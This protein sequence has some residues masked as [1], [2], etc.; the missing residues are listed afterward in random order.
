M[1]GGIEKE[2]AAM[3]LANLVTMCAE[4]GD[5]IHCTE[6]GAEETFIRDLEAT[7]EAVRHE[8]RKRVKGAK[9]HVAEGKKFGDGNFKRQPAKAALPEKCKGCE[10]WDEEC[11]LESCDQEPEVPEAAP[12][13][14]SAVTS[15]H[16]KVFPVDAR[17]RPKT[18]EGLQANG[19]NCPTCPAAVDGMC[20]KGYCDRTANVFEEQ[21]RAAAQPVSTMVHTKVDAEKTDTEK[22]AR[23]EGVKGRPKVKK[24]AAKRTAKVEQI[25]AI[26]AELSA[27]GIAY[28]S[29]E[30]IAAR[31][32]VSTQSV[33]YYF[34]AW[35][36]L[37]GVK[38]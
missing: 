38:Q 17:P 21:K 28:V 25:K 22:A 3:P 29:N 15:E 6:R 36:E 8:I 19:P 16:A 37:A 27:A 5:I 9:L 4:I 13:C 26:I 20:S 2:I 10:N 18:R 11:I 33:D 31:M 35:P 34:R 12:V 14:T 24:N 32:D 7:R 23:Q 1:V 30:K